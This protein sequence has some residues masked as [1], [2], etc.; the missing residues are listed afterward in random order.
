VAKKRKYKYSPLSDK[1]DTNSFFSI[2]FFVFPKSL[3]DVIDH[4]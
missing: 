4:E 2:N 3:L 1:F